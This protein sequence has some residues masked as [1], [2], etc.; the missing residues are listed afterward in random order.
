MLKKRI[1]TLLV[2]LVFSLFAGSALAYEI[3]FGINAGVGSDSGTIMYDGTNGLVGTDISVDDVSLLG[4]SAFSLTNGLLNFNT[5]DLTNYN[6]SGT[7]GREWDFAGG[8]YITITAD[9]DGQ[10]DVVLL[11][12][13]WISAKVLEVNSVGELKL[14]V[15]VGA[16]AD[17]KNKWLL[18][19]LGVLSYDPGCYDQ[20][21]GPFTG[22]I[23]LSFIV[24]DTDTSE[25]FTSERIGSGDVI[26]T[27]VPIPG[28]VWLL[29]SGI[30]GLI[31]VRRK[32][33]S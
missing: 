3:D 14:E 1:V 19:E 12:G 26:N 32:F 22:S 24:F 11:E 8:G 28:A 30:I 29:G 25:T 6:P 18:Y 4:G 13:E 9:V 23:N 17:E 10:T 27:P 5:G 16:F 21:E 15:A 33:R 20:F 7:L 2:V 31:G